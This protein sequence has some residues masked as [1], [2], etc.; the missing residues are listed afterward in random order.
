MHEEGGEF[1]KESNELSILCGVN[2][3]IVIHKPSE[4]NAILWPSPEV[5]GGRLQ[6]F[7]DFSGFK[8][9]KKMI[10]HEKYLHQRV[11]DA[12]EEMSKSQYKKELKESQL[13]M[14]ELLIKD[15]DFSEVDLGQLGCLR[16]FAAQMLKKLR[17]K[18][19]EHN[20][21]ERQMLTPPVPPFPL[22]MPNFHM[23]VSNKDQI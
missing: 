20:D 17:L 16:S 11:N 12:I 6:Q 8:R 21:Q 3:G 22:S 2:I 9:A 7:L 10:D 14:N 5:F 1:D 4:N 23:I 19:D 18:N 13:L 15:K